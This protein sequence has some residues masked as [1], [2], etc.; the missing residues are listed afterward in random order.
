MSGSPRDS[1]TLSLSNDDFCRV[2]AASLSGSVVTSDYK[3]HIVVDEVLSE[4]TDDRE[5]WAIMYHVEKDKEK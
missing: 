4:L 2:V 1:V 3:K 5:G